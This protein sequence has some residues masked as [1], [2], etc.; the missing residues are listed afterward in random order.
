[1][2]ARAAAAACAIVAAALAGCGDR[3]QEVARARAAL[4]GRAG[5][6][7]RAADLRVRVPLARADELLDQ[8]LRAQPVTAPIALPELGPLPISVA[9]G[10]TAHARSVHLVAAPDDR[11]GVAVRVDVTDDAAPDE[12]PLISFDLRAELAPEL[13]PGELAIGFAPADLVALA[14]DL[15]PRLT[16]ALGAAVARRLPANVRVPRPILDVAVDRLAGYL[17]TAAYQ[18]LR[19]TL[20]V[21]LGEVTRLRVHLPELPSARTAIR[22]TSDALVVEITTELPVRRGLPPGDGAGDAL[23][24]ELAA[25]AVAE[26]ANWALDTGLAPRWYDRGLSPTPSGEFR[27]R[28]DYVAE[29]TGHPFKV[30]AF[31]ER[32]GCSYFRVGVR[33]GL[34]LRGDRLEATAFDRALEAASASPVIEAAAWAKYFVMGAFDRSKQVAAST[35]LAAGDRTLT[36]TVTEVALTDGALRVALAVHAE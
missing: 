33:A 22:S 19:A 8:V 30:Y 34:R 12:P 21:R 11:V 15:G 26:V 18:G 1:M 36:T 23:S 6:P 2:S 25:G 20:L 16:A 27:P 28:F 14:P 24:V 10:L 32:G 13:T 31:Q 5:A 29:D 7:D 35:R 3:C 4:T 9:T 17:T